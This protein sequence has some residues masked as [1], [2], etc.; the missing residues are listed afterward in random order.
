MP[1]AVRLISITL[2]PQHDTSSVLAAHAK[3]IGADPRIWTLLTGA[4]PEITAILGKFG[5]SII[6]DQA[7]PLAITHNLRT[8]VIDGRGRVVKIYNGQEWS[9]DMLLAD[10][11]DAH[12][13]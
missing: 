8:A 5:V 11:R 7:T 10:L 6:H 1:G 12:A 4:A 2:D 3:Q 9:P 13:R